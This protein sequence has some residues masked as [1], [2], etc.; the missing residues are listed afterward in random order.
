MKKFRAPG[1]VEEL[2]RL[3]ARIPDID[4]GH[5]LTRLIIEFDHLLGLTGSV[6]VSFSR[7]DDSYESYRFVHTTPPA[8]CQEY[9]S[10]AWY[11]VDPCIVYALTHNEPALI[12][13]LPLRTAGQRA[14]VEAAGRHGFR[15]GLVI[16]SHSPA[17]RS[18]LGA[19][20]IVSSDPD[21]LNEDAL[22]ALRLPL[23][24]FASELVDWW[25]AQIRRDLLSASGGLSEQEKEI[26]QM[27]LHG[28]SSK[29]IAAELATTKEAID[30]RL[31][32]L[33]ARLQARSR[34]E[35]AALCDQYGLLG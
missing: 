35:A 34:K 30:Q 17:G 25:T 26:L 14:L 7:G 11:A 1:V 16:P 29:N 27:T 8:W 20:Y 15:S 33:T 28:H 31:H 10:A 6:F 21:Y 2:I 18:R 3:A 9:L 13:D 5:D 32:R 4:E 23:R 12:K 22:A 19:L 24:A